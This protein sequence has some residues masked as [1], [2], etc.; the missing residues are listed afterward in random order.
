MID[1]SFKINEDYDSSLNGF[2]IDDHSVS[3][4]EKLSQQWL[5]VFMTPCYD[6]LITEESVGTKL[7]NIIISGVVDMDYLQAL[8]YEAID[9]TNTQITEAQMENTDLEDD[10]ILSYAEMIDYNIINETILYLKIRIVSKSGE[11][12]V[13]EI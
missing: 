1:F 5:R 11:S 8:A 9:T 3:G 6:D 10:E 12:I 13:V 7:A 2:E 4:I